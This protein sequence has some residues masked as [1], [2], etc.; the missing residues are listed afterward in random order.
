MTVSTAS[1]SESLVIGIVLVLIGIALLR[2]LPVLHER[3]FEQFELS[4][5]QR[6]GGPVFV[7]AVGSI[8]LVGGLVRLF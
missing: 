8:F 5:F 6:F 3:F 2:F 7:I 4:A 1:S